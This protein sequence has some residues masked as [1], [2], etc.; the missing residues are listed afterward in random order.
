MRH[1]ILV[2]R[3]ASSHTQ[4]RGQRGLHLCNPK[5]LATPL[6]RH[7]HTVAMA[8]ARCRAVATRPGDLGLGLGHLLSGPSESNWLGDSSTGGL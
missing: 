1:R 8:T 2:E 6:P 5:Y 3:G 4:R 7:C